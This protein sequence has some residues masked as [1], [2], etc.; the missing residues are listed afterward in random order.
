MGAAGHASYSV[1]MDGPGLLYVTSKI[2]RP[3]IMTEDVYM[4]WYD[5][6]HIAEIMQTSGIKD[7]HRYIDVNIGKVDKPYLAIYPMADLAFTQGQEFKKIKVHSKI[8]PGTGLCYDLAD[9]DVRYYAL[10][11]TYDPK[12]SKPGISTVKKLKLNDRF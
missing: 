12:G 9:L 11:Q 10:I 6:D 2:S 8:L 3:D 4:D 5:N 7:A 1:K